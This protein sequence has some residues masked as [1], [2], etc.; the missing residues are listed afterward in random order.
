[1]AQFQQG[2]AMALP[3]PEHR[4]DVAVM[5]LVLFFVPDP[6]KGVAEMVRVV[7]PGGTI[8]AYLWDLP[9]GGFP[10]EP[11]QAEMRAMGFSIVRP[12]SADASRMDVLRGLW[13]D[14]G[15]AG[16]KTRVITVRRSFPDFDDVW[17][18][19][20]LSPSVAAVLAT[21]EPGDIDRLKERLRARLPADASGR[22]TYGARANA[23]KGRVPARR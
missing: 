19:C 22:I 14:A 3:F 23:I 1:V 2:D 11:V 10:M 7:R 16:I 18:T 6:V 4:F 13:T 5:A 9:G 15:L 17:A 8:T 21:M 12:P 20:L